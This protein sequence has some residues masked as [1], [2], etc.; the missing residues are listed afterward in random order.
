MHGYRLACVASIPMECSESKETTVALVSHDCRT[1]VGQPALLRKTKARGILQRF[2]LFA[3]GL[4]RGPGLTLWRG[5]VRRAIVNA[6]RSFLARPRS[7]ARG[8]HVEP[9]TSKIHTLPISTLESYARAPSSPGIKQGCGS[10]PPAAITWSRSPQKSISYLYLHTSTSESP[11]RAAITWSRSPQKS[12]PYLYPSTRTPQ[13]LGQVPSAFSAALYRLDITTSQKFVF[14]SNRQ[15][16]SIKHSHA[17][18]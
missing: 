13:H 16:Q 4:Q 11:T 6:R 5:A 10:H 1:R 8:H 17:V 9:F 2:N 14:R 12:I 15:T 7:Y 18:L 3:R